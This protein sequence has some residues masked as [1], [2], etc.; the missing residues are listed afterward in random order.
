VDAIFTRHAL[1]HVRNLEHVLREIYRVSKPSA[2]VHITV[3]DFTN[4]L[5]YSDYTHCRFFG[6]YS[7]DYFSPRKDPRW[8]VPTYVEDV[9]F[10]IRR[11]RLRFQNMSV[12]RPVVEAIV[13]S[14]HLMPYVYE[15]KLAW[16][17][18]CFE[19]DFELSVR[20]SSMQSTTNR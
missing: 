18:P 4:A 17:V 2:T 12:L 20:K 13:N 6:Y 15:S 14:G 16:L 3:P 5:G 11:K 19:I 9:S 8:K 10:E 1:E 7:F